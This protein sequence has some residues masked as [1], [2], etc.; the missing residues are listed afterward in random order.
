[1]KH[2]HEVIHVKEGAMV[3][4]SLSV[5]DQRAKFQIEPKQ[6]DSLLIHSKK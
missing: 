4:S 2:S 6:V 3:K 5:A 1:M